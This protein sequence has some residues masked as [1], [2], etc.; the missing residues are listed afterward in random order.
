MTVAFLSIV[1]MEELVFA[2]AP[3]VAIKFIH[4]SYELAAC[5]GPSTDPLGQD[6]AFHV[7]VGLVR[8]IINKPASSP[9]AST[10]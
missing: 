10:T 9:G 8:N 5:I 4:P 2:L 1:F 3:N 6:E 7:A